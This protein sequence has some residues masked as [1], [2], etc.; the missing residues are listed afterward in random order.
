MELWEARL[1]EIYAC[2]SLAEELLL[3]TLDT[4]NLDLS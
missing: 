1:W 4:V 2:S 3:P